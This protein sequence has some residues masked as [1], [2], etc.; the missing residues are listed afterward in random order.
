MNDEVTHDE[1]RSRF[2]VDADGHEAHLI[3]HR[4]SDEV[5]DF[6]STYVPEEL[7]GRGLA[8]KIVTRAFEWADDHGFSVIPSCPYVA[9]FVKKHQE[10]SHLVTEQS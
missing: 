8:G 3:Y 5:V 7:R 10:Y 1:S 9:A 2:I 6:T 4:V